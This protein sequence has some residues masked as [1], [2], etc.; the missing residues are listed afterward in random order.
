MENFSRKTL[1]LLIIFLLSVT[2]SKG[3]KCACP[4]PPIDLNKNLN[5]EFVSTEDDITI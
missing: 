2:Y 1:I 3:E 4:A 5:S